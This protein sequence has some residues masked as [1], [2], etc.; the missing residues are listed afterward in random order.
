MIDTVGADRVALGTNWP[1]DLRI[2]WPMAW[3]LGL[4]SLTQ[5]EK[6]LIL[7]KNLELLLGI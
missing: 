7:W 6:E 5:E 3:V 4:K 2:D 1:A